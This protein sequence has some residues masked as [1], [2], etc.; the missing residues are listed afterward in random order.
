MF[1]RCVTIKAYFP[2]TESHEHE[3]FPASSWCK[4]TLQEGAS[5]LCATFLTDWFMESVE[6]VAWTLMSVKRTPESELKNHLL[7][8]DTTKSWQYMRKRCEDPWKLLLSSKDRT[9]ERPKT[10]MGLRQLPQRGQMRV[11]DDH[12]FR[13]THPEGERE[14]SPQSF[15][16]E[17]LAFMVWR[18]CRPCYRAS[19][20]WTQL[21]VWEQVDHNR[22]CR[23]LLVSL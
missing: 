16:D 10:L 8:G 20:S 15:A 2:A 4:D 23:H 3:Q 9:F 22:D 14:Q 7:K 13:G 21:P 17:A 6:S 5:W 19:W 1:V 11:G 12:H 18:R